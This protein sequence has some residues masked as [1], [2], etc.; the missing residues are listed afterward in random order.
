MDEVVLA[1]QGLSDAECRFLE[2]ISQ[3]LPILADVSRADVLL[4]CASGPDTALV[5]SHAEPHS[6]PSTRAASLKGQEVHPEQYPLIFRSL[7]FGQPSRRSHGL[8]VEGTPIVQEVLPITYDGRVIGALSVEKTLIEFERHRRRHEIFKQA[9]RCLQEMACQGLVKGAEGLAPFRE[10]DGIVVVDPQG[11]ILYAS[12]AAGNLYRKLGHAGTLFRRHLAELGTKDEDLVRS[13][14]ARGECLQQEVEEGTFVWVKNALPLYG[15]APLQSGWRRLVRMRW[16]DPALVGVMLTIHDAT[17]ERR[18]ERELRLK[19]LM[20][21][22]IQHRVRNSLQT[23][24]ALL[25]LEARRAGSEET[26]QVLQESISRILSV[27]A[28]HEFLFQPGG[29][30]VNLRVLTERILNQTAIGVLDRDQHIRLDVSGSDVYLPAEQATPCALVINELLLNA[31]EHGFP[32]DEQGD[33]KGERDGP[34]GAI[35]VNLEEDE[36]HIVVTIH[37]DGRGLP[38]DFDLEQSGRLGLRIV[39]TLVEEGLHGQFEIRNDHGVSAIVR[40]PKTGRAWQ[41]MEAR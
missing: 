20:L 32:R 8:T 27:A 6:V 35:T 31:V 11:C 30:V 9:L 10:H 1:C 40:F 41:R 39:Q 21:Q 14:I 34:I 29:Q 17:E 12:S 28:V 4:F 18:K 5:V 24:T 36:S 15:H 2:H 38:E 23:I 13:A 16:R 25:R 7:K 3:G 22:E 37:D 33:A 26:R 19:S